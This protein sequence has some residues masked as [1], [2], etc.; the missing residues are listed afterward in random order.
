MKEDMLISFK[1]A[2]QKLSS[3]LLLLLHLSELS[4]MT[5]SLQGKW[6]YFIC[7][8]GSNGPR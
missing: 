6:E 5:N 7:I 8:S 3:T 4:Y 2:S 1:D